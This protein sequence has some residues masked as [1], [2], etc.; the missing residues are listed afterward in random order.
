MKNPTLE[1]GLSFA[2]EEDPLFL[3]SILPLLSNTEILVIIGYSLPDANYSVD[4]FL[5]SKMNNLKS[6]IIQDLFAQKRKNS[7]KELLNNDQLS[8]YKRGYI[9][10]ETRTDTSSFY[11][12]KIL[13]V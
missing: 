1:V 6:I 4:Q 2:W 7:L 5:I 12:P 3:E 9:T 11:I 8:R 13:K 10:I